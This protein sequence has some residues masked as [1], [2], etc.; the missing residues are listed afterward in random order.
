MFWA[1]E[2]E[3]LN[4]WQFM[5]CRT[6]SCMWCVVWHILH[7]SLMN[8]FLFDCQTVLTNKKG[9]EEKRTYIWDRHSHIF[10]LLCCLFDPFCPPVY[11][12]HLIF[13]TTLLS[14]SCV[15]FLFFP[16]ASACHF[17]VSEA[18]CLSIFTPHDLLCIMSLQQPKE[19]HNF[20]KAQIGTTTRLFFFIFFYKT[21]KLFRPCSFACN[22]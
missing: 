15:P 14:Q 12:Y 5:V 21:Q 1:V 18:L 6:V 22:K 20:F 3:I 8:L 9:G 4:F 19:L 10:V 16:L 13:S 11:L 2:K 7:F 17:T